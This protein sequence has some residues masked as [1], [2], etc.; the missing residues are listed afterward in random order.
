MVP[1]ADCTSELNHTTTP[2]YCAPWISMCVLSF[3]A[4][5]ISSDQVVGGE[6]TLSLRYQSSCV[7]EFAGA[8]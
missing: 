6:L 2:S 8:A 4:W 7:F 5:S 3:V 1:P